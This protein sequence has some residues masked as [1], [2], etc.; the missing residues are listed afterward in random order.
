MT[1]WPLWKGSSITAM[2]VKFR[3]PAADNKVK[4]VV[5]P[6][7]SCLSSTE[8]RSDL[9]R[10]WLQCHLREPIPKQAPAS[11][12]GPAQF[13]DWRLD[14]IPKGRSCPHLW[15]RAN[16]SQLLRQPRRQRLPAFPVVRKQRPILEY[17]MNVHLFGAASS[18]G[19]ANF[20]LHQTA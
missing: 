10:V 7:L 12:T 13:L 19:V 15:Y 14:P 1:T 17:R 3:R 20:C 4:G 8:A 11:R 16:V 2:P 9:R 18:P 5:S 6:T